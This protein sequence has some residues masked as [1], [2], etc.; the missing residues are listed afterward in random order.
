MF[1]SEETFALCVP[2]FHYFTIGELSQGIIMLSSILKMSLGIFVL[3]LYL[4]IVH[5]YSKSRSDYQ[6]FLAMSTSR[7]TDCDT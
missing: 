5:S 7:V 6:N 3:F 2:T 4:I 1:C